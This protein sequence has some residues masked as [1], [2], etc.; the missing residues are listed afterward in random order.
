MK[1]YRGTS[2]FQE[3]PGFLGSTLNQILN[4]KKKVSYSV[5]RCFF[6]LTQFLPN[7]GHETNSSKPKLIG[8][9]TE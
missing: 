1:K 3:F 5:K 9:I 4:S 6:F 8:L 7:Q 2:V